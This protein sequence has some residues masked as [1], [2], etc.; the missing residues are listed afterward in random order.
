M[1]FKINSTQGL[2]LD[3][4]KLNLDGSKGWPLK[5]EPS[6]SQAFFS[7]SIYFSSSVVGSP[8]YFLYYSYI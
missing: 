4:G 6:A 3:Y 7:I 2:K 8:I 5:G 1:L